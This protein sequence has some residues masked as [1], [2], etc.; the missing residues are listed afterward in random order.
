MSKC[1]GDDDMIA[2]NNYRVG[3]TAGNRG[4]ETAPGIGRVPGKTQHCHRNHRE[5]AFRRLAV[6]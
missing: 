2:I 4:P 6:L 3:R 5:D 1:S